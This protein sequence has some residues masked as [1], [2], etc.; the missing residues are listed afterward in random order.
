VE[1]IKNFFRREPTL[2]I[3]ALAA[4]LNWLVGFQFDGLSAEQA[5]WWMVVIN[6][7]L[8][9]WAA[10]KTRPIAPQAFTY[11]ITS[12][13]GLGAAY[14]LDYSQEQ[15]GQFNALVMAVLMFLTRGQVSPT[16]DAGKT[17]V[18]GTK[19]TTE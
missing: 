10:I 16:L 19:V 14:G 15:L 17:G 1:R 11:L 13:A 12:A 2:Y 5:S 3:G 6:A 7:V 18:L 9:V 4:L 8:G